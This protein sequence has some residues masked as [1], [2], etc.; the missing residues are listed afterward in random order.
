MKQNAHITINEL[1]KEF[2]IT[3]R[4][5]EKTIAK[6]KTE[7]R[8]ERIGGDKGGYWKIIEK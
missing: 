2:G 7:N 6:L 5:I 1:S 4:S 3:T 8:I